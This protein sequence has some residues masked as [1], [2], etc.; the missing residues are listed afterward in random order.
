[1]QR[2]KPATIDAASWEGVDRGLFDALR[3][4][5]KERA[6][7]R[8]VPAYVIFSDAT[9]RDLARRRP[10]SPEEMRKVRGVG[11]VKLAEQGPAFL[12]AVGEYCGR[13]GL[14]TN[15]TPIPPAQAVGAAAD[16][17]IRTASI[18]AFE[19][20]RQNLSV[21]EVAQRLNRAPSTVL[22]Y[23][24]DYLQHDKVTDPSPW[25]KPETI[26]A[27][28]AAAAA[29][30]TNRLKPIYEALNG[31]A[32]YE[33]IRIVVACLQLRAAADAPIP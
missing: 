7:A 13:H 16:R 20:F 3:L 27:V 1:V 10:T 28:E 15:V 6:D 24:L 4:L 25:V 14:S 30:D 32:S 31:R 5:R 11:E 8:N 12:A 9:L 18:P 33:E 23:L 26:A 19:S 21:A 2:E 22:G 17:T 29:S